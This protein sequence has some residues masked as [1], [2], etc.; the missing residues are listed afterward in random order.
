MRRF[1]FWYLPVGT[2][3]VAAL[4]FAYGFTAYL[5]GDT[6]TPVDFAPRGPETAAPVAAPQT[7]APIILGDSLAR[8][9][10]DPTG[11]GIAGRL[12][13]ELRRRKMRARRT[14]NVAVNGARTRD[15]LQVLARPNVQQL[16]RESNVI[17]VSIGGNDL[18]GGSDWRTAPPPDPDAV[19]TDVLARIA[20]AVATIRRV[21]PKARIFFIG[22][23]NPFVTTPMGKELTAHVSR[24]NARLLERFG[25]DAD[26]TL[27]ATADLFSHH[28]RLALDRFH[29]SGEGYQLIARRIA[30]AL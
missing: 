14:Y 3:L 30:D 19:M 11:L 5:R 9:A 18:W 12:D 25:S 17:I 2:A 22:L 7:I 1:L 8:G 15:L 20:D 10:G 26:F 13:D 6:G 23:Y 24:W 27:V 4:V 21:N 28:D 29:P 16:L